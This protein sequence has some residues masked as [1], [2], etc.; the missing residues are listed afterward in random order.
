MLVESTFVQHEECPSCGSTD[1]LARYSDGHATCFSGGCD[2]YEHGDGTVTKIEKRPARILEMTGVVAAIPDRRINQAT[3]QRYGVTVEYGTDGTISKHH[4]PYYD[5]DTGNAVGTKVRIVDNKS[6]YATGGFDN[7]GM[8]GQ[9]AFKGGG[10]YI[11]ITEGETDAMAV[12]EMFDGKWPAVSIRSGAAGA[13]KDIK[14][15]LEWLETFDNV[16]ICFDND[17]AGQAA[18]NAVLGLF[19]PNKA[20]NVKLPMKDAGDMLQARKVADF[21]KEWWNAKTYQPDGIISF[22]QA[23]VWEQFLK[24]GTEEVIPLP[25]CF[26]DLNTKMNGGIVA[27][28][29]TVIGALTSIGKTTMVS[30]LINGFVTESNQRIGCIFL[31]SSVGETV[32]NLLSPYAGI[33]I[34]NIPTA[35]RDYESYHKKYLEMSELQNLHLLDHQGSSETEALFGKIHYLVKGL[36]CS[37]VVID[38]LQAAVKSNDNITIDDFMDRCLKI[39]KNTG[40]SIILISHMRQ[41]DKGKGAHD[42]GEYDLKG[43]SSINQ[44]AFNTILL[45]RDKLAEDEHEKN[46]TFVQLVKCRRTG[47][48]G[49]AGWLYYDNETARLEAVPSPLPDDS[50]AEF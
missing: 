29:V 3:A 35:E 30:N 13:A 19:T 47:R 10:K 22:G 21:V 2:H 45:S 18:A 46:C 24:R 1:N 23:G 48:T 50:N 25:S 28:E 32:E 12:N 41:P 17:K 40:V 43:S 4:Y 39:A 15:N 27:G 6:F 37:V 5:K 11:T 9:Q 26:G 38:P 42:V 8:F 49:A 20:K 36:E 34:S 33:N 16:V 14:A 44:I 7:A 31:E